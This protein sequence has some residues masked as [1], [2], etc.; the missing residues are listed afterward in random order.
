MRYTFVLQRTRLETAVVEVDATDPASALNK[1]RQ[2][3][4]RPDTEWT[5]VDEET[6]WSAYKLEEALP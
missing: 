2:A 5:T 1:A 6:D 4:Q 3:A